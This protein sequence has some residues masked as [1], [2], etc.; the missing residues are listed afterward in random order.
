MVGVKR[1]MI[2]VRTIEFGGK[3]LVEALTGLSG[4]GREAVFRRS[5][6]RMR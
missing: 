5:S 4:E 3:A 2:L 1:E 6:R